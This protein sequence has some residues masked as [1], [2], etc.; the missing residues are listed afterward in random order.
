MATLM[1]VA[2]WGEWMLGDLPEALSMTIEL[3][4]PSREVECV[5]LMPPKRGQGLPQVHVFV[6]SRE[7]LTQLRDEVANGEFVA[8]FTE[9]PTHNGWGAHVAGQCLRV[10]LVEPRS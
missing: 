4:G 3:L 8:D 7:V 5:A 1:S 6:S 10:E 9:V 2:N